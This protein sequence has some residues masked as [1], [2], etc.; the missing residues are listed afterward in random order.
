[1][2]SDGQSWLSVLLLGLFGLVFVLRLK[3]PH[4]SKASEMAVLVSVT[5]LFFVICGLFLGSD[6]PL[7][8]GR[9]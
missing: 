8:L 2:T 4:A 7:I 9:Q 5:I 6:K 3:F 1:M